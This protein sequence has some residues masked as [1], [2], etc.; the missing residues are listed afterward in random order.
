[1]DSARGAGGKLMTSVAAPLGEGVKRVHMVGIGGAGMEALARLLIDLGYQVSGSDAAHG[2]AVIDLRRSGVPV[3]VG[4]DPDQVAGADLLVHSSAVAEENCER[5][6][7][8]RLGI[9]QWSRARALGAV[10]RICDTVAVAGTHGK[11]TTASLIADAARRAGHEPRVAIGGWTGGRPQA[12]A[13]AGALLVAEA[14]EY[15]R[16]FQELEPWIAVI[17]NIE[18]EHVDCYG[19]VDEL[20]DAFGAFLAGG[21]P[22]GGVAVN[23]DDALCL[24]AAGR[25]TVAEAL[26]YGF[27]AACEVRAGA[28]S[29]TARGSAFSVDVE[30]ERRPVELG[31]PGRHNV[32]NALA[33]IAATH[34]MGLAW[35]P[36]SLALARFTGVDRRYQSKGEVGGVAIVDD[37]AHHPTEVSAAVATALATGRKVSAVFQPHTYSRTRHFREAF[38]ESLLSAHRVCVT[39]VYAARERP[40]AGDEGEV[41][42]DGLR[43]MGHGRARFD[44]EADRAL[45]RSLTECAAGDLLLVMGAGDIGDHLDALLK[46]AA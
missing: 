3:F 14:D 9:D 4:H 39:S 32:D 15:R 27:D 25:S 41:I 26:T 34:L 29:S 13:P 19:G 30:G 31:I 33:A 12:T 22:G 28:V 40:D 36:V 35:E 7:A 23:G 16:G 37:Y 8:A 20:V 44:A 43:R 5:R 21:R 24:E 10:S 1:M 42:I 45:S 6:E 17:T 18:M 38:A 46:D 11:T 2:P